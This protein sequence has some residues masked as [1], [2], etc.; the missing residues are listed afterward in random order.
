MAE[1][2]FEITHLFNGD[3]LRGDFPFLA[4]TLHRI[5]F[6]N[7]THTYTQQQ[8]EQEEASCTQSV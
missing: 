5:A 6:H 2:F 1:C 8:E 4:A 7:Y 3:R